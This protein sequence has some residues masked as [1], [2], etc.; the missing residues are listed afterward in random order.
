ML[1]CQ[2]REACK[3]ILGGTVY[4]RGQVYYVAQSQAAGSEQAGGRPAV[5]VSSDTGNGHSP[6]VEV[7]YLTTQKKHYLPTHVQ[8]DSTARPSTALCEQIQTICKDRLGRYIGTV[9][10]QEMAGIDEALLISLGLKQPYKKNVQKPSYR[11]SQVYHVTQPQAAGNKRAGGRLAVIVSNDTGNSRS[12]IVEVVYLDMDPRYY[13][14]TDVLVHPATR[15][16]TALCGQIQTVCQERLGRYIGTLSAQEM[17]QVGQALCTGLGLQEPCQREQSRVS[18]K[19]QDSRKIRE[20]EKAHGNT[21][22]RG[23]TAEDGKLTA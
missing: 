3:D 12:T 19:S 14:P 18:R 15:P 2:L 20:T 21:A 4:R 16:S 8:I 7:V 22:M 23:A 10:P 17:E 9:S 1:M 13:L 5:I 11:R 6:T